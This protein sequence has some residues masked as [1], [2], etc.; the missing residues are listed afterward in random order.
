MSKRDKPKLHAL[1]LNRA[2]A[3][4][5]A[6]IREHLLANKHMKILDDLDMASRFVED[7]YEVIR[8]SNL[9]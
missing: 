9:K 8:E 2:I 5:L 6:L 7:Q 1:Q 3:A 4:E